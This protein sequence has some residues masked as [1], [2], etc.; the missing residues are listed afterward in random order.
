MTITLLVFVF[1]LTLGWCFPQP[2]QAADLQRRV[3][4]RISQIF[5]RRGSQK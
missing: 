2:T 5:R 1:G 3:E 4:F